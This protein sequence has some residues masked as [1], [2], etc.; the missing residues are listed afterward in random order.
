MS[1]Y[2]SAVKRRRLCYPPTNNS[3]TGTTT[4]TCDINPVVDAD[5]TSSTIS[6]FERENEELAAAETLLSL[7]ILSTP[8]SY[9][10]PLTE[11]EKTM[12]FNEMDALRAERDAALSKLKETEEKLEKASFTA[13]SVRGNDVKCKCSTGLSWT[14]F[15]T[16]FN[17]L[18]NFISTV[19]QRQHII[20]PIDQFFIT[21]VK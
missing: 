21:L 13:S 12:M 6:Q 16:T 5:E 7:S 14:V 3:V 20:P 9:S 19:R 15:L 2:N 1:R 10:T 8:T 11:R 17:Y 18:S 4:T